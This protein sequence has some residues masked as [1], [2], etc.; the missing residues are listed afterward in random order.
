[1]DMENMVEENKYVG[2][3]LTAACT[4]TASVISRI[5]S[6]PRP[7]ANRGLSMIAQFTVATVSDELVSLTSHARETPSIKVCLNEHLDLQPGL[8]VLKSKS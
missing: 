1:M 2:A 7:T 5:I 8:T 3:S 4:C 6:R